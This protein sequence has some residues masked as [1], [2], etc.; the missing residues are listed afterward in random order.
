LTAKKKSSKEQKVPFE[1]TLEELESIIETMES[2]ETPL[3]DMVV[4]FE[5]GTQL[6]QTC[7]KRLAEAELKIETIKQNSAELESEPFEL[8]GE[9]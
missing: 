8:Q 4:N 3:A 7:Q 6:L 5:K 2:G 9:E 1:K